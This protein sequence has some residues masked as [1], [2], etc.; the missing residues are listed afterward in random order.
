MR[1]LSHELFRDD[2]LFLD[3][4]GSEVCPKDYKVSVLI[5]KYCQKEKAK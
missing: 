5:R 2:N 1:V 3:I 4:S